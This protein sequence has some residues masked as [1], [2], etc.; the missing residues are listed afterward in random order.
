MGFEEPA[1]AQ[2]MMTLGETISSAINR[3]LSVAPDG[4]CH[5][6]AT[7]SDPPSLE[8]GELG[9]VLS[10]GTLEDILYTLEQSI[11]S[12]T[13][14]D[15]LKTPNPPASDEMASEKWGCSTSERSS[16]ND[17][18]QPSRAELSGVPSD[19]SA[20]VQEGIIVAA[21]GVVE[22]TAKVVER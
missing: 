13:I 19:I 17:G 11:D 14:G 6:R 5:E 3:R 10:D 22:S 8:R 4:T 15:L 2:T 18:R 16:L 7:V 1:N 20:P 9:G 12:S 21:R